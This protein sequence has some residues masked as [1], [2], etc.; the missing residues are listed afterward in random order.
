MEGSGRGARRAALR[1]AAAVFAAALLLLVPGLGR[2]GALDS[3]DA[4][5]LE[6]AREMWRSGDWVVP[7]IAGLPH[8]HKPPLSYWSAAAGYSVFGLTP[9]AGRLLQQLA[10]AVTAVLVFA[11]GRARIGPRGGAAAAGVFLTSALVFGASRGL[12]TDLLQ[13]SFLTAGLMALYDGATRHAVRATALGFAWLGLSMWAKGPIALFVAAVVLAPVLAL[14]GLRLPRR[15]VAVGLLLFL[16]LGLPWYVLLIARDPSLVDYFLERQLL[17][18]VT[19][20]GEGHVNGLLFLPVRA[21]LGG[22]LPWTPLVGLA[23]WRLRPRRRGP[24]D[25]LELY[26]W[27][28]TLVPLLFFELFA[29]KLA[30]YLLPCYPGAALLVGRALEAGRL[31]DRAG[32]A[33]LAASLGLAGAAALVVAVLLAAAAWD[34]TRVERFVVVEEIAA[35]ALFAAVLFGICGVLFALALRAWRPGGDVS[36]PAAA[37][38]VGV[39]F[40]VGFNALAAPLPDAAADARIVRSVPG[41][42]VVEYGQFRAGLL[43]YL[44]GHAVHEVAMYARM[45]KW[46][47]GRPQAAALALRR[48]DVEVRMREDVP[49]FVVVKREKE[50]ELRTAFGAGTVRRDRR[51]ALLANPAAQRAL[52][53]LP[54]GGAAALDRPL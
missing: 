18:R 24:R 20:G 49:T 32:R 15:G 12:E 45:V 28:W 46:S 44:D 47:K 3:T 21:F 19:A 38:A 13:L 4:R 53:A 10:V 35:P 29:T 5:Y 17:S 41:A 1:G 50:A 43:F 48:E 25:P 36:L 23:L 22:F 52:A 37:T 34:P 39:A 2:L 9:F 51:L 33:A 42:R 11:F 31:G 16:V 30:T 8:L 6:V 7:H 27:L 40:L 26:L 14:S 54:G